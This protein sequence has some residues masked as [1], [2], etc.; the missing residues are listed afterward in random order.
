[1]DL[2]RSLRRKFKRIPG[3]RHE[4]MLRDIP[5]C[6]IAD[7]CWGAEVYKHVQRPFN[8]PFIGLGVDPQDFRR[9]LL[10]L[11]GY[12]GRELEF[13]RLSHHPRP[14]GIRWPIAR[15]GDVEIR[16]VHYD[17][18]ETAR[19]KWNRRVERMDLDH[20]YISFHADR[21]R[22]KPEDLEPF[23]ALPHPRKVAFTR[24]PRPGGVAVP[25]WCN[26]G[27]EFFRRSQR[28][29]DAVSWIA[30]GDP[31]PRRADA[32]WFALASDPARP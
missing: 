31:T 22:T 7:T 24:E 6:I 18:F 20:L 3:R 25:A 27:A 9:I 10:D 14:D 5:F 32:T 21:K 23:L 15:L 12:L 28:V 26:D 17:D 16:C 11:D 2:R 13:D 30:T 8:T 1:M 4:R 29:F 19:E